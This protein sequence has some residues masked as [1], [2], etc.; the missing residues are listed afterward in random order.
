M[1]K[2]SGAGLAFFL[3]IA[4]RSMFGALAGEA[5]DQWDRLRG[6]R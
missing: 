5:R 6:K 2:R 4:L 3:L 1:G